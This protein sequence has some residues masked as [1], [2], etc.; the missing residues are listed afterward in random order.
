MRIDNASGRAADRDALGRLQRRHW[1]RTW[2][3]TR[4]L[5]LIISSDE[6]AHSRPACDTSAAVSHADPRDRR[7]AGAV[8]QVKSVELSEPG[9]SKHLKVLREA[10]L[11]MVRAEGKQRLYTLRPEPLAEVDRWS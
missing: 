3:L 10:G 9:V 6:G 4:T 5:Y 1:R 8:D 7:S 2:Y 11:V